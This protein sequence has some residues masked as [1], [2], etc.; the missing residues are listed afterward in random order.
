MRKLK[1]RKP[2]VLRKEDVIRM[3]VTAEQRK[4][5]QDAAHQAGLELSSWIRERALSAA[6]KEAGDQQSLLPLMRQ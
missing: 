4:T 1:R 5:M 2:N 3:R 6:R